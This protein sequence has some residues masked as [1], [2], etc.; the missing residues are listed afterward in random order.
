MAINVLILFPPLLLSITFTTTAAF[1]SSAF[2]PAPP[3]IH[4]IAARETTAPPPFGS[5]RTLVDLLLQALSPSITAEAIDYPAAGGEA[6]SASVAAGIEAVVRQTGE[7]AERCPGSRVVMHG[8]SQGAQIMD[9]AFCG[10]PDL[11][12]FNSTGRRLVP[13]AVANSTVAIILMGNPRHVDGLPFNVGNA[14][15]G[16]FAARPVGFR[17]PEFQ[18]RI[19]AYCDSPD[20]FC[21]NGNDPATHQGYGQEFGQDALQFVITKMAVSSARSRPIAPALSVAGTSG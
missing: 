16:G 21:S 13:A 15:A 17:C 8:Y 10:G 11:P 6:Y 5:S 18:D 9:D 20:P 19:R 7:F 1:P 14:T 2:R 4:I 3:A 12:S